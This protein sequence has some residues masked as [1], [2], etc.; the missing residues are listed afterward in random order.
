MTPFERQCLCD[1]L[2]F[3]SL[4]GPAFALK[5]R[6]GALLRALQVRRLLARPGSTGIAART[7]SRRRRAAGFRP[8]RVPH[9]KP[10]SHRRQGRP[11]RRSLE[12]PRGLR[13]GA[14]Q[15]HDRGPSR[16]R[17]RR[18]GA[19]AHPNRPPPGLPVHRRRSG[20]G[21]T[22]P[23]RDRPV[24]TVGPPASAG[25]D[26]P[27]RIADTQGIAVLPFAHDARAP[28]PEPGP[29]RF[30]QRHRRGHH[31]RTRPIPL[32]LCRRPQF[33]LRPQ[34]LERGHQACRARTWRAPR[35]RGQRA[36]GRR[37]RAHHGE[38]D[39]HR[40]PHLSLG[41]AVRPVARR[42]RRPAGPDH[43]ERRRRDRPEAGA[44]RDRPRAGPAAR[45]PWFHGLLPSRHGKPL[46][47]EPGGYRQTLSALR[48]SHRDRSGIRRRLWHGGVL[49]RSAQIL[50]LDHRPGKGEC[51]MRATWPGERRIL[52]ADD[53]FALSKAAHAIATSWA[54][55]TAAPSSSSRLSGS[56]RTWPPPGT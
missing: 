37:P 49:L 24:A 53:A 17:R 23:G 44:G 9:P 4:D 35:A 28:M 40:D 27:S 21:G 20:R 45:E 19:A 16:G 5:S 43:G 15:P 22:G 10:P 25:E 33:E 30:R 1:S 42:H 54:T 2:V 7:R 34:G 18:R 11:D 32:A 38:T 50:W 14:E 47:V 6:P 39:R 41:E 48:E 51:G 8:A 36:H 52:A 29:R 12:A 31:D 13:L 26:T 46:P 55:S 56:I 3:V